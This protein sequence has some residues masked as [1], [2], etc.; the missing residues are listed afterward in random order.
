MWIGAEEQVLLNGHSRKQMALRGY[1]SHPKPSN[2]LR[3]H[4]SDLC[5]VKENLT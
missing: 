1:K 3:R 2:A 4:S 5:T